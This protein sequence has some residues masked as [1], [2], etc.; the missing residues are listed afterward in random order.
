MLTELSASLSVDFLVLFSFKCRLFPFWSHT[1]MAFSISSSVPFLYF[2]LRTASEVIIHQYV[3]K[4]HLRITIFV[5]SDE[6]MTGFF[7]TPRQLT[8]MASSSVISVDNTLF[9]QSTADEP[10]IFFQK[11]KRK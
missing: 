6:S 9:V 2:I 5:I 10:P 8:F 3:R 7:R 4:K 11:I 1:I